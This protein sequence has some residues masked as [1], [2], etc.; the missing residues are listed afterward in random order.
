MYLYGSTWNSNDIGCTLLYAIV[1]EYDP[2]AFPQELWNLFL[3][4]TRMMAK[5]L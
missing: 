5:Y 3:V 2:G 1:T 4:S